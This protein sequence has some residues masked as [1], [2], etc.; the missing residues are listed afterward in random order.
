[1][2]IT[3]TVMYVE[4]NLVMEFQL[5]KHVS[6]VRT[7][8]AFDVQTSTLGAQHVSLDTDH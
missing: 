6:L 5:Q 1:M 7:V 4:M 8:D 3:D 2:L